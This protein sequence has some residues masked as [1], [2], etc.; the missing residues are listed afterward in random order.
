MVRAIIVPDRRACGG[1]RSCLVAVAGGEALLC[2]SL[3][4]AADDEASRAGDVEGSSAGAGAS[5][6]RESESEVEGPA[7]GECPAA[8]GERITRNVRKLVRREIHRALASQE[9]E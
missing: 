2:R 1:E 6:E 3:G 5:G 8:L 7:G 4:I 9:L